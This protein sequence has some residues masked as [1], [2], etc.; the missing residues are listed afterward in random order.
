MAKEAAG[1]RVIWLDLFAPVIVYDIVLDY[2][3]AHLLDFL[4]D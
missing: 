4:L 1:L 2:Q 3:V